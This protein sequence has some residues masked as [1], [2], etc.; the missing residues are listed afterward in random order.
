[1]F[2]KFSLCACHCHCSL[3]A[4]VR[5][6]RSQPP[7][8]SSLSN[9]NSIFVALLF[10]HPT[11]SAPTSNIIEEQDPHSSESLFVSLTVLVRH[12]LRCDGVCP[13]QLQSADSFASWRYHR[14]T[15]TF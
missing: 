15:S 11:A 2:Q 12:N 7:K 5:V 1:M 6:L 4:S 10:C 13:A 14:A 3:S 8:S 9:F